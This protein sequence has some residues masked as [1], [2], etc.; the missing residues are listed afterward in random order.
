MP[1]PVVYVYVLE[2]PGTGEPAV[3]TWPNVCRKYIRDTYTV[4]GE[5]CLPPRGRMNLARRKVNPKAGGP[6]VVDYLDVAEF[7]KG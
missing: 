2:I 1:M 4:N 3:F 5:L 7:L 6:K